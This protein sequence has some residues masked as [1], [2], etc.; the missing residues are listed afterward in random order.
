MLSRFRTEAITTG[1]LA[2][3]QLWVVGSFRVHSL[4]CYGPHYFFVVGKESDT[5]ERLI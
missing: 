5:T 2:Q 3:D 1:T 4:H